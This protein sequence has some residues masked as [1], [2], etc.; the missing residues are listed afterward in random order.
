MTVLRSPVV[1]E[2]VVTVEVL[3]VLPP[4]NPGAFSVE[5][6]PTSDMIVPDEMVETLM[7]E[8]VIVSNPKLVGRTKV[9]ILIVEN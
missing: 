7:V 5:N 6:V 2:E 8:P 4:P 3:I 1:I 9:E